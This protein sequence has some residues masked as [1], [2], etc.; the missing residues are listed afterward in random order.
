MID[1][2]TQLVLKRILRREAA[3]LLQ[4][5]HDAYPWANSDRSAV[6]EEVQRISREEQEAVA[7]LSQYLTRRRVPP[8]M[9]NSYPAYFTSYNFVSLDFLLPLLA[10]HQE[11]DIVGLEE[12][13]ARLTEPGIRAQVETLLAV[14]RKH[15]GEL[16][17]LVRPLTAAK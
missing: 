7:L 3:T 16:Q 12:D 9:F 2:E 15:L 13:L 8:A 10:K 5:V 14:K 6:Q 1:A 17:A 4:Y 11:K